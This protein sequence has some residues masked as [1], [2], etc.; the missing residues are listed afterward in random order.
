MRKKYTN[1]V[2]SVAAA[3]LSASCNMDLVPK[4]DILYEQD[5]PLF[6]LEQDIDGFRTSIYTNFRG[7]QGGSLAIAEELMFDGFNALLSYGN[8]YGGIHTLSSAFNSSE[9]NVESCWGNNYIA[10]DRYNVIINEA[11]KVK[12]SLW[13]SAR[14]MSGEAYVARACS[15]MQ[16]ARHF[17][18]AYNEETAATD[19]CV[20]IVLVSDQYAK[21]ARNTVKEVYDRIKADLDSAATIFTEYNVVGETAAEYFTIDCVNA[22]YARYYLD[23]RNY[24]KAAEYASAL[25]ESKLY[26]LAS[27]ASA[28]NDLYTN[29]SGTEPI[30]QL[31]VSKQELPNGYGTWTGFSKDSDCP[32]GYDYTPLY[33]PS[34]VLV[35]SYG[36]TDYRRQVWLRYSD[37][38]P[39]KVNAVMLYNVYLFT[40]FLGNPALTSTGLPGAVSAPKPFKISEMYLI[41]AES[42]CQLGDTDKA[43]LYLRALTKAR[44]AGTSKVTLANIQKEWNRETVGEGLR[45]SNMKR[46][47]LGF[48]GRPCQDNAADYIVASPESDF[49]GKI[50][51]AD[52]Y[53][54]VWP[55][56][57]YEINVNPNLVQNPGY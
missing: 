23:T 53:R 38:Y 7:L 57:A 16:L 25:A 26:S 24:E 44:N 18:P 9:G 56:P 33:I 31:Y 5:K 40:K 47:G 22:M 49:T 6:Q 27:T 28:L 4:N 13:K 35:D 20:P 41:A 42:Y 32:Q 50:L 17:A 12:A 10:I 21:P 43:G 36:S 34:K 11:P 48:D 45:L 52:D 51:P 30:M 29:D 39:V 1:I 3:V 19:L 55:V 2:L 14:K 8:N 37:E 15:Y 46:W 54:L